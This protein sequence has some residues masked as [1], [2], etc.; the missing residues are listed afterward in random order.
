MRIRSLLLPTAALTAAALLS[1][2]G[3][4]DAYN[5]L[6]GSLDLTQR[7]FRV[8][9]NFTD[10]EANSN[11][12]PHPNFPGASGA[13]RA[14]WAAC[15]EWGSQRHGNGDFDP[16]QPGDLGSG[17]ANFDASFQGEATDPGGSNSNIFSEI[18]GFGGGVI[19]YTELPI[20][21]G[22]RIRFYQ[23]PT[24]WYDSPGPPPPSQNN[25]DLQAV[26]THEY[27]HAL[28]LDHSTVAGV[29]MFP[30]S[31]GD[32]Y[33]QRSIE[34][35]DIAGV[36]AIYGV[37]AP[38]KPSIESFELSGGQVFIHGTNFAPTGN[39]VW[40]TRGSGTGDGT[41]VK[42]SALPSTAGG[43]RIL[44][45]I[46]ADAGS[47]DILVET[48]GNTGAD[49]SNAWPFDIQLGYCDAPL[50]YGTAKLNSQGT[51]ANLGFTG[52]PSV[53]YADFQINVVFG[54]IAN[55]PA[56][57]FHGSQMA[58][59]PFHGGTLYSRGP[60]V[61]DQSFNFGL[62]GEAYLDITV[63]PNWI[64]T[65]H[66]YQIWYQDSGDASGVGTSDALA[67]TFCP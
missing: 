21:D 65:T 46:P 43:T 30:G 14:I 31:S 1:L 45:P 5:L 53:T 36:Q 35:D 3:S 59:I 67:V 58:S 47:G 41:P 54:G 26:A 8:Y 12:V 55:A 42:T 15:V 37:A 11:Q 52:T 7:D 16:S 66:Y 27:G 49:L 39:V 29:S 64:G 24:V 50:L 22:W 33:Y 32:R 4:G 6:G 23:N 51:M 61:R 40:F 20:S 57:L 18:S 28:G 9:N 13:V 44:A 17:G 25:K 19:A 62:F 2:S 60:F 38:T 34:A 56:V 48:P 10:V 63:D